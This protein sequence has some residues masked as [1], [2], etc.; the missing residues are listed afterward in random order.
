ME[1]ISVYREAF[2]EE[3]IEQ[4]EKMDQDLLALEQSESDE[5]I[6]SIFRAAHT[7]KG[8]SAAMGFNE[9]KDL[10]HEVEHMLDLVRGKKRAID[11]ALINLLFQALDFL[12]LLR[13]EYMAGIPCTDVKPF[14][15][16]VQNF[17]EQPT[18]LAE[19]RE[20]K[21][22][23]Y[24]IQLVLSDD[25]QMKAA[26]FH[27]IVKK[28]RE[29]YGHVVVPNPLLEETEELADD[30][31]YRNVDVVLSTDYEASHIE[32]VLKSLMDVE[33]AELTLLADISLER[34]EEDPLNTEKPIALENRPKQ[35]APTI[36]VSVERLEHLMNLVGELLIDQT[37]FVQLKNSLYS[38]F[39]N[40]DFYGRF[41]EISDRMSGI[42]SELQESV[43][44][45]RMLPIEHLF[46][47]MPRMVRD[48]SQKLDKQVEL[49]LDGKETELDRTLIEELGD[50][51]IHLIRNAIDHGIESAA[52]RQ[53]KGKAKE[54]IIRLD[55]YHEDNQIIITVE[56]N[57][58]GIS[59]EKIK[60]SALSKQIITEEEA[61][62][63]SERDA[64]Y[65]IFRPG[66]STA[67]SISEVSGRGVGMDIVRNQIE[68]LN[69]LIDIHTE[70][71]VG[72]RFTI[73]LPLTLAIITGLMVKVS[74]RIFAIPMSNV[75]EIVRL[76][77]ER[78]QTIRGEKVIVIRDQIIPLVWLNDILNYP[79]A[80]TEFSKVLPVVIVG[81]ADKKV[82][83]AVDELIGNQEI[84][85]KS[86][87]SFLGKT[88]F[89]AGATI[90]GNGRVA[91]ILEVAYLVK[92]I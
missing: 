50:P 4:L 16:I 88:N 39:S 29:E 58:A 20:V 38:R 31:L 60:Q 57:G 49:V 65:L 82:A 34:Q 71:D 69:G 3:L 68:R 42:V 37:S 33:H 80:V 52:I 59:A 81:S 92:Q 27:L 85:I 24:K 11:S 25:C 53:S 56:D 87:G 61:Q 43:M 63:L 36:R 48:L 41:E 22:Q 2:V 78:I 64:L 40:E 54:G 21:G 66:F 1:D 17:A 14:I 70:M 72:T 8:S 89:I 19:G 13:D 90:L 15:T 75:L 47:R 28:L 44:K 6:Q 35:T 32:F 84:V 76:P 67:S 77:R 46:N 23:P 62:R 10:T 7:I 5:L 55:A 51:L 9:M 79:Q 83:L 30:A 26:R 12:K 86:M 45:A 91:L 74:G 73:R 18:F